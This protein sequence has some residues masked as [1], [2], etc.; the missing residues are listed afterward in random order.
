MD[1]IEHDHPD[2][3]ERCCSKMILEWLDINP[4]ASWEDIISAV[5]SLSSSDGM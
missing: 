2:S 1:N 5:D 4:A 3:C